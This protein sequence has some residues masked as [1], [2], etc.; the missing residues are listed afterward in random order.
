[1]TAVLIR[2]SIAFSLLI[3]A[4][5]V[6]AE[7][8][9]EWIGKTVPQLVLADG[10]VY[11]QVTFTKLEADA[12]TIRHNA[13]IS[14][15]DLAILQPEAQTALGYDPEKAD[16]ARKATAERQVEL[17]MARMAEAVKAAE[18][19]AKRK[20]AAELLAAAVPMTCEVWEVKEDG[21]VAYSIK[22]LDDKEH[23][24]RSEESRQFIRVGD[25]D[26]FDIY[27]GKIVD[28]HASPAGTIDLDGSRLKLWIFVPEAM[29]PPSWKGNY[30]SDFGR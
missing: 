17:Q 22:W 2:S 11:E 19:E 20:E 21:F 14:R 1:M 28:L 25:S 12:V 15:I 30:P 27:E 5:C 6:F 24:I 16:V 26:N 3:F 8:P 18:V 23:R 29:A 7:Q 4:S 9:N 10:K 13:G